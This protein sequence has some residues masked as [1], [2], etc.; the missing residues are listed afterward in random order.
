MH[1]MKTVHVL[2]PIC[3]IGQLD[4]SVKLATTGYNATTYKLDTIHPLML[5]DIPVDVPMAH[6]LRDHGKLTVTK[7]YSK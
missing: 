1:H 6:Q 4:E 2:Q 7:I 5:P 3:G